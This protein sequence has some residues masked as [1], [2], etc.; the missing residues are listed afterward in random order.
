MYFGEMKRRLV[1]ADGSGGGFFFTVGSY[2]YGQGEH[3]IAVD[4]QGPD[5]N[6]MSGPLYDA[7]G[8]QRSI[9]H[10]F[11]CVAI[12]ET[13]IVQNEQ[14]GGGLPALAHFLSNIFRKHSGVLD[15]PSLTFMDVF[16][17]DLRKIIEQGGGVKSMQIRVIQGVQP[18][19]A[20][21]LAIA[22][23]LYQAKEAVANTGKLIVKW[24]AD[25]G[26]GLDVDTVIDTFNAGRALVSDLDKVDLETMT[27][28][29]V[30][31]VGKYKAKSEIP[32]TIDANGIE[33]KNEIK[34]LLYAY[35]DELRT[36][37]SDDWRLIDDAGMFLSGRVLT[38]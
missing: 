11:R 36:P 3:Q 23:P 33:H 16:S 26:D 18:K 9:L 20:S 14:G 31:N 17:N 15:I 38:T 2:V 21:T 32:V 8:L 28:G 7:D 22:T 35:L 5:P 6:I 37:D 10:E 34:P 19:E 30:R 12:G 4:F 24:E 13:L 1:Q 29:P 27:G 25:D